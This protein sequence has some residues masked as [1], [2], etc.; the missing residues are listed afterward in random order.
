MYE[1]TII[2]NF[3]AAVFMTSA[4]V[5]SPF[6]VQTRTGLITSSSTVIIIYIVAPPPARNHFV[7]LFVVAADVPSFA[8]AGRR[9]SASDVNTVMA[10][11]RS[12]SDLCLRFS[13]DWDF[14]P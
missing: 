14:L 6:F 2:P 5:G 4:A 12:L 3:V 10:S 13:T 8:L 11:L 7:S 1:T 9:A